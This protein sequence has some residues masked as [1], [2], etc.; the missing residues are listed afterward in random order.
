MIYGNCFVFLM[1]LNFVIMLQVARV[2]QRKQ[3]LSRCEHGIHGMAGQ[4][5]NVNFLAF[6]SYD[7]AQLPALSELQQMHS[8]NSEF[9]E[10]IA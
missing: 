7:V 9:D 6:L 1:P 5:V 3:I 10:W 2:W 4:P 8:L